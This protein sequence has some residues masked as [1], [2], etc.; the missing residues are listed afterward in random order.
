M[1]ENRKAPLPARPMF[2]VALI[3]LVAL[4]CQVVALHEHVTPVRLVAAVL[5]SLS[6]TTAA[7]EGAHRAGWLGR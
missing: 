4:L 3:S 5:L 7:H 2:A 6:T 1:T